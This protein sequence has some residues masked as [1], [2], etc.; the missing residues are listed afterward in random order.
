M[1]ASTPPG[2][3]PRSGARP[4]WVHTIELDPDQALE[5][6]VVAVRREYLNAVARLLE[7]DL[8]R[9]QNRMVHAF[10]EECWLRLDRVEV[11]RLCRGLGRLRGDEPEFIPGAYGALVSVENIIES[12]DD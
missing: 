3:A 10:G 7:Y 6:I 1:P 9:T 11:I 12:E 4:L 5:G 2:F 8:D